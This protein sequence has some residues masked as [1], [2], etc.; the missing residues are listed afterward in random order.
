MRPFKHILLIFAL[1]VLVVASA[2][3]H[4]AGPAH[5]EA[6]VLAEAEDGTAVEEQVIILWFGQLGPILAGLP[7]LLLLVRG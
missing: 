4:G 2:A 1:A 6:A 3:P 5:A 7:R